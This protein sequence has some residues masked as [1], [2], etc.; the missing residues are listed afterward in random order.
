VQEHNGNE[1]QADLKYGGK[2]FK[3]V[4]DPASK[5]RNIMKMQE[6]MFLPFEAVPRP[7]L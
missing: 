6:M 2:A 5:G 1:E 7:A 3:S 4:L